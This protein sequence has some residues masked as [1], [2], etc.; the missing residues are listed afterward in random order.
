MTVFRNVMVYLGLGPDEEYEDGYLHDDGLSDFDDG[1]G[2]R[3]PTSAGNS[4]GGNSGV[5]GSGVG[6]SGV[7]DSG[8]RPEDSN[9][10]SAV[11]AV[12]PLR[13][14]SDP[15]ST[16][17]ID[18]D[19]V[20]D[21][22]AE[23]RL[24]SSDLDRQNSFTTSGNGGDSRGSFDHVVATRVEPV[25]RAVPIERSKPKAVSPDNFGD[26]KTIADEFKNSVPVIMNLQGLDRELAR[27]LIDFA[28]GVC[29]SLNGSMEKIA[30]QVFLLTP[31]SVEVSD[32]DRRRIEERGYAN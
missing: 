20:L 32:E 13:P 24:R 4:G 22:N 26:A 17:E 6:G 23:E 15:I 12:R 7:P 16:D 30:S 2:N 19:A 8:S 10:V 27:R 11:G 5:G 31:K 28:S 14:V 1:S 25:V 3:A 21:L 9:S 18:N 29:Y